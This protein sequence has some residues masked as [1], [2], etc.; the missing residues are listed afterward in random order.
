ME[1]YSIKD[2]EKLTGI[3]DHTIRVWERRY[4]LIKPGR[5]STNRRRYSDNELRRIINITILYRNGFKISHIAKLSDQEIEEK[6]SILANDTDR[7]DTQINTLIKLMIGFNETG[8]NNLL[9]RSIINHGFEHTITEIVLPFLKRVGTMW[10]TG[11][12]GVGT[13]HFITNIFRQRI[14]SSIASLSNPVKKGSKKIILFLPE[15]EFHEIGL[16]FYSYIARKLGHEVLY[17]GQSTPLSAVEIINKKWNA[18]ILIT[19]LMTGFAS[20]K[21][22]DLI[23]KLGNSFSDKKILVSGMLTGAAKKLK[24]SNVFPLESAGDLDQHL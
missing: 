2:L 9:N 1:K 5:T 3:K 24:V 22:D 19:G 15:D 16:L 10:Q 14:I 8:I 23:K 13:E 18:D 12:I 20:N 6:V 17:L 7:S 4:A 21:P 11:S